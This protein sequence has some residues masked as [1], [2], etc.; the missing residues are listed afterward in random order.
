MTRT[1]Y[2]VGNSNSLPNYCKR[3]V[4]TTRRLTFQILWLVVEVAYLKVAKFVV[5]EW[6][7]STYVE[8]CTYG[9]FM[10]DVCTFFNSQQ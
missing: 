7:T 5:I 3:L 9:F 6:T 2:E 8:L 1:K 10:Y 4:K